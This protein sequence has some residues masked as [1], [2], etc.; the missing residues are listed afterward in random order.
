VWNLG[1]AEGRVGSNGVISRAGAALPGLHGQTGGFAGCE[2][3]NLLSMERTACDQYSVLRRFRIYSSEQLE[4]QDVRK[5][6]YG[7]PWFVEPADWKEDRPYAPG[8]PTLDQARAQADVWE[9]S[10][11]FR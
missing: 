6:H 10:T 5:L 1:P 9:E 7:G 3:R 8:Y 4:N 11:Q 2:R